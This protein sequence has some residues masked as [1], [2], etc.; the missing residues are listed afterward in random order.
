MPRSRSIALWVLAP[1]ALTALLAG[2]GYLVF[3]EVMMRA[4]FRAG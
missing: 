2:A 3:V 1:L 4:V